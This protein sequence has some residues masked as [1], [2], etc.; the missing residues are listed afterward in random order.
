ME[1]Y[2]N[3]AHLQA[4]GSSSLLFLADMSRVSVINSQKNHMQSYNKMQRRNA[5]GCSDAIVHKATLYSSVLPRRGFSHCAFQFQT[6]S[7]DWN[8][9]LYSAHNFTQ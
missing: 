8:F 6:L 2:L 5:R 3:I 9:H 4:L 7:E 1:F